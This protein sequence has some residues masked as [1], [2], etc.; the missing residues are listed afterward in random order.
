[1]LAFTR[2]LEFHQLRTSFKAC[3]FHRWPVQT[4]F[5]APAK[6]FKL[7]YFLPI[8]RKFSLQKRTLLCVHTCLVSFGFV[9][10]CQLNLLDLYNWQLALEDYAIHVWWHGNIY[11]NFPCNLCSSYSSFILYSIIVVN[12]VKWSPIWLF[13]TRNNISIFQYRM[14]VLP[15]SVCI[16][17]LNSRKFV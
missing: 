9:S 3:R 6:V 8:P 16:L 11:S 5:D 2:I 13:Y 4:I 14:K 7:R 15:C 12:I 10:F 17:L 1:M